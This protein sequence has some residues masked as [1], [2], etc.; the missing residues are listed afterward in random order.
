MQIVVEMLKLGLDRTL[1]SGQVHRLVYQ[2]SNERATSGKCSWRTDDGAKC[3]LFAKGLEAKLKPVINALANIDS[4]LYYPTRVEGRVTKG[5]KGG[6]IEYLTIL[7]RD[8]MYKYLIDKLG[9]DDGK[10]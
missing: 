4:S 6:K 10:K 7:D 1:D 2:Y 5:S 9:E 3:R 8:S